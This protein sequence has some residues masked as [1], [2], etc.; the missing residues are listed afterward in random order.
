[1]G[2]Y[3]V[4]KYKQNTNKTNGLGLDWTGVGKQKNGLGL[5]TWIINRMSKQS[6]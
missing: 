1:M 6:R 4:Y 3:G 5:D 2:V